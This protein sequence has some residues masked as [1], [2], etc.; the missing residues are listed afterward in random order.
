MTKTRVKIIVSKYLL[1]VK[2]F[3]QLF[4]ALEI[5]I[6]TPISAV[7]HSLQA[8]HLRHAGFRFYDLQSCG[9]PL[10]FD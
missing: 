8:R 3:H 7:E 1:Q 6:S 4:L 2:Y 10:K 9:G 5:S